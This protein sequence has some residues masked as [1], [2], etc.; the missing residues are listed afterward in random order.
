MLFTTNRIINLPNI[1]INNL[2]ITKANTINFLSVLYDDSLLFKHH[3]NYL[4]LKI[5]RHIALLYQI[6][7]FMP[8]DVLKSV[9]YAHIYSLLTYCNPIWCTTYPTYLIP[10][11]LQ[12]KK[13]VRIITNSTYLEHTKPLFKQTR[14]L[15]LNDI[16]K[17][18]IATFMYTNKTEMSNL[19]PSH[20]FGTR[21]RDNLRLP[22]HRLSKFKH[23]T[24]YLGPV[25]W[26][27]IP[28]Q[29]QDAPSLNTFK[30]RLKK[31]IL[32]SY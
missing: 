6:K 11:N 16:T 22:L 19:L 27:T 17:L 5:S 12:L 7:D 4:T 8:L 23:S 20:N 15:K 21:H 25:I 13:I 9:Y 26:N 28:P 32:S 14:L 1:H 18:S 3:I 10:L 29:I 24:N 30:N 31:H 2:I